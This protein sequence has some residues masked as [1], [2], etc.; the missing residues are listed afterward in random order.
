MSISV[1]MTTYN[2]EQYVLQQ[3]GSILS[4]LGPDDELVVADDCSSD[5]TVALINTLTDPR[6]RLRC[7]TTNLGVIRNFGQ[8]LEHCRGE[9]IFLSDQDD[10]WKPDRVAQTMSI[11]RERPE[12]TLVLANMEVIDA[13]GAL[14]E[15]SHL[16]LPWGTGPGFLR[17]VRHIIKNRYY[18]CAL[19]F[20]RSM[21]D[22]ILP[23]PSTVPMHDM[24]IGILND[25]Y[26]QTYY[27]EKPLIQYRRH[28]RNVT[29]G[30]RATMRQVI[31]WRIVLVKHLLLH[32]TTHRRSRGT[33]TQAR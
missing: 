22:A 14:L 8:A 13:E 15:A 11:F 6:I 30:R 1:C 9:L 17:A 33:R 2:G 24:W 32:T 5:G 26:G 25:L 7:N 29:P 27:L 10:L 23:I 18:G 4:Q 3:I 19:A 20:R 21:L 28:G 12:V 16:N 31:S